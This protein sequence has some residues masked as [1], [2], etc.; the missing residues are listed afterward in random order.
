M[1]F[2]SFKRVYLSHVQ[3]KLIEGSWNACDIFT[4][5]A[6]VQKVDNSIHQINHYPV[7]SVIQPLNN[8]S[9]AWVVRKVDSTIHWIN[10]YPTDSVLCF[11]NTYP[12]DSDLSDG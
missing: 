7:D 11:V 8:R 1:H 2:R 4:D 9:Q 3:W 12:L 5:Q 10:H 6:P